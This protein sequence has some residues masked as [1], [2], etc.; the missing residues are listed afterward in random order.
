MLLGP[1]RVSTEVTPSD[2]G[3][4]KRR[5]EE[6]RCEGRRGRRRGKERRGRVR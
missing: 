3:Y 5:G 1:V 4:P 2:T 6:E